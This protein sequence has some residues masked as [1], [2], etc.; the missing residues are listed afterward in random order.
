MDNLPSW[1]SLGHLQLIIKNG[2]LSQ[3]NPLPLT[4]FKPKDGWME[5]IEP[6]EHLD[7]IAKNINLICDSNK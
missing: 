2:V 7:Q 4:M 1:D 5:S 3:K 6:E